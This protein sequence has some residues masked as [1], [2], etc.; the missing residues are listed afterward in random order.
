MKLRYPETKREVTVAA[1]VVA[2]AVGVTLGLLVGDGLVD[3]VTY[4]IAVA[5]GFA[6]GVL[7]FFDEPKS[8][9]ASTSDS[10]NPQ[11]NST[12]R[13]PYPY[14]KTYEPGEGGPVFSG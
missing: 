5:M 6:T 11:V 2:M 7:L 3:A 14:S 4:G 8:D 12:S 1:F 13:S 10:T 9:Q